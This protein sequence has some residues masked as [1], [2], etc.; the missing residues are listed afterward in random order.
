[1]PTEGEKL[2]AA[3]KSKS[4]LLPLTNVSPTARPSVLIFLLSLRNAVAQ[5][6][7]NPSD[8]TQDSCTYSIP[9][10]FGV[11]VFGQDGRRHG[12]ASKH[13]LKLARK[14]YFERA[15]EVNK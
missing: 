10:N 8:G 6:L 14:G 9:K 7:P 13:G 12:R 5:T 1:M 3:L 11:T 4:F 2:T 15:L